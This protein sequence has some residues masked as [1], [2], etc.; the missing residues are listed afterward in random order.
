MP[1]ERHVLLVRHGETD[2]NAAG[3]LQGQTD[4]PLNANGRAQA[5]ALAVRLRAEGVR[6]I[7]S[8]DLSRAR[9]TAELVGGALGLEV[10][11]VDEDLRE[12]GYG[13]WEGL[14]RG[15]CAARDPDAWARHLADPRTPPPGGETT[16]ALLAR[17]VPA[18]HRAA[19]RLATPALVVTHG[20][21]MRAFLSAV[22]DG[23]PAGGAVAPPVV[24][25]GG[26]WRVRLA[27]GRVIGAAA[28]DPDR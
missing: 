3:R 5:L 18:I 16:E 21:V 27:G 25:N 26:V 24:P 15:E 9:G 11:L 23:G 2:W 1:P 28:L 20:G 12:R 19:E 6:A 4:V 14:T 8:S 7:G 17:V 13:A 10:A 22:L